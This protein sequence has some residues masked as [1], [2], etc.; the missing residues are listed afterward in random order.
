MEA[1]AARKLLVAQVELAAAAQAVLVLGRQEPLTL[2]AA[3]AAAEQ[4][5]QQVQAAVLVLS[6]F[7][8]R[9]RQLHPLHSPL[10]LKSQFQ[11]ASQQLII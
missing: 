3:E 8:I 1:A 6:F 4:A 5:A 10:R 9:C 2:A 7:P 11:Q